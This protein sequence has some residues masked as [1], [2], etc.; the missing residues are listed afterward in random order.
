MRAVS[1]LCVSAFLALAASPVPADVVPVQPMPAFDFLER[2]G[3]NIHAAVSTREF[4]S[5]L[6]DVG[7]LGIHHLRDGIRPLQFGD[8]A[9]KIRLTSAAGVDWDVIIP[10]A[11]APYLAWLVRYHASIIS[12][13]GPNE[14]NLE[15][16]QFGGLAGTQAAAQLQH[17]LYDTVRAQP[18]LASVPI[19][20]YSMGYYTIPQR[21]VNLAND[22]D[23][24]N[25]HI[26]PGHGGPPSQTLAM[27]VRLAEGWSHDPI[28][29]SEI[30]YATT[31]PDIIFNR[32]CAGGVT[33]QQQA[34]YL[35]DSLLDDAM[36]GVSRTY[37]YDLI[38]D[39]A[40]PSGCNQEDHYGIFNRDNSPK[41]AARALHNL[42]SILADGAPMARAFRPAALSFSV[43][44]AISSL[45]LESRNGVY[46]LILWQEMPWPA[47][48]TLI[49]ITSKNTSTFEAFD[50]VTGLAPLASPGPGKT[51]QISV[52]LDPII[53]QMAPTSQAKF[54][55]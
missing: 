11:P 19:L 42:T 14:P 18:H 32:H 53:V 15:K 16:L 43:N 47:P 49:S 6:K 22:F 39:G 23:S 4:A 9:E 24:Q 37:L 44:P 55:P 28:T 13:E 3:I 51:F 26:Y 12:L 25:L 10:A 54:K 40:D 45:L 17:V 33:Q 30:G 35:L 7:F 52:G 38:D 27:F 8:S 50:P 2:V 36:L 20:N 31:R 48:T 21:P 5:L 1:C 46:H 29:V 41:P 34:V